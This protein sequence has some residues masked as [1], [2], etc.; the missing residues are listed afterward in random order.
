MPLLSNQKKKKIKHT[1][2]IIGN[3]F[4]KVKKGSHTHAHI[5]SGGWTGPVGR[6]I[7]KVGKHL[8]LVLHQMRIDGC[9]CNRLSCKLFIKVGRVQSAL[10]GGEEGWRHT[11]V[12]NIV[13]VDAFEEWMGPVNFGRIRFGTAETLRGFACQ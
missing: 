2:S 11:F 9:Q 4:Y 7:R 12:I 5:S 3:F 8:L 1:S 13:P 6:D 10:A